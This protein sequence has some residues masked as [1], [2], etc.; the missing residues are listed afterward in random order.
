MVG[1]NCSIVTCKAHRFHSKGLSFFCVPKLGIKPWKNQWREKL[2]EKINRNDKRFNPHKAC[3]CSKHFKESCITVGKT[4]KKFLVPG[5][6]PTE[7]MPVNENEK[8]FTDDLRNM[9]KNEHLD[10]NETTLPTQTT[11]E[12][13]H[14][15]KPDLICDVKSES[16]E[17]FSFTQPSEQQ[18]YNVL[19][20]IQAT[21]S[22][23]KIKTPV[24]PKSNKKKTRRK[25]KKLKS[26]RIVHSTNVKRV[27]TLKVKQV[28]PSQHA[29]RRSLRSS[30]TNGR[31]D[32]KKLLQRSEEKPFKCER[33]HKE[34]SC[35]NTFRRHQKD[36][37]L[38]KCRLAMDE[39][40]G[41]NS[42][43]TFIFVKKSK[44]KLCFKTFPD[45]EMEDH[46]LVHKTSFQCKLCLK[47]FL[48]A[49]FLKAHTFVHI[50]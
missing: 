18:K 48:N 47:T 15:L 26:K 29:V 31:I 40:Q 27:R 45:S 32:Y 21:L 19:C 22:L 39:C 17:V 34:Y 7:C 13:N 20:N 28:K 2:L 33:C 8:D 16:N 3:I 5:S 37:K 10:M 38:F 14:S 23:E 43:S 35:P 25:K 12:K 9:I 11:E 50:S 30:T 41:N 44:C 24:L 46:I 42:G 49:G 4:G 36:A 6:L 1:F